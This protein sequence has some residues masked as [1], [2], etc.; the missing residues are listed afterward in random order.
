MDSIL[1]PDIV[2]CNRCM[3][4]APYKRV[5]KWC[6][7]RVYQCYRA[8]LKLRSDSHFSFHHMRPTTGD[9]LLF[10][11]RFCG[12]ECCVAYTVDWMLSPTESL[13]THLVSGSPYP[14]TRLLNFSNRT[15]SSK[16][17][18]PVGTYIL[19]KDSH[20]SDLLTPCFSIL[21]RFQIGKSHVGPSFPQ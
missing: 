16:L 4:P 6:R 14:N 13:D 3:A 1:Y 8:A 7:L 17:E 20:C 5:R 9:S 2:H 11:L 21:A 15:D 18:A 19:D 10:R 12:W